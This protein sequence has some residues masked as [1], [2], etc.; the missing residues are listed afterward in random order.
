MEQNWL[1]RGAFT[2]LVTPLN[3]DGKIDWQAYF[4][5]L[6][7][8]ASNH[9]WLAGLVPAG[10]TGQSPILSPEEHIMLNARTAFFC[11]K[12]GL[13]CIAGTGSNSTEEATHYS[14][15][16]AHDGVDGILLVDPYYNRPPSPQLV[17]EYYR[18]I[19]E[20]VIRVNPQIRV[21]PY[22]IPGRT[23][24]QLWP[25]DLAALNRKFPQNVVAVKEATGSDEV[26]RQ[27][28]KN[29]GRDFSLL[30]GDDSATAEMMADKE[31][32]A[33]GAISV[34]SNLLPQAV[35]EMTQAGI[36]HNWDM[37]GSLH[38][39]LSPLFNLVTVEVD[40]PCYKGRRVRYP[41]PEPIMT[42]MAGLGMIKP[43]FGQPLGFMNIEAVSIVRQALTKVFHDHPYF[44]EDLSD[45]W[46]IDVAAKLADN[47]NW[48]CLCR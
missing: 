39:A 23:A 14:M 29:C 12:N 28:R 26:R 35:G 4:R 20:A 43:F 15:Q 34:I 36:Q 13:S 3:A 24:T 6:D 1:V 44:F 19:I 11:R 5:L 42:M 32:M 18:P 17:E 22:I 27:I 38:S 7:Y 10:T 48:D 2:A 21:V 8:Q 9:G 47:K 45:F 30:S 25:E 33:S 31:I 37:L 40:H 41:N 16:A 46:K